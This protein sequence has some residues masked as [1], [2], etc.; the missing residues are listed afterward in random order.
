MG[1]GRSMAMKKKESDP[2]NLHPN[3]IL[4]KDEF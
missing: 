2:G 4:G 1:V 3:H